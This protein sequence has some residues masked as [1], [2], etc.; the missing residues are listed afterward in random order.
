MFNCLI[1]SP[2]NANLIVQ[3]TSLFSKRIPAFTKKIHNPKVLNERV[4]LSLKLSNSFDSSKADGSDK[5][6]SLIQN[7]N[8]V[9]VE[10]AFGG[11]LSL[12]QRCYI[13]SNIG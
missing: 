7:M 13:T 10:Y 1:T 5:I 11:A 2:L 12:A 8:E 3:R 9:G 4:S 6:I